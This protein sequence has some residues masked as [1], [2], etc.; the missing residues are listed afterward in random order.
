MLLG[1]N[2]FFSAYRESDLFGQAIFIGLFLLS[3]FSWL[4]I[5]F[6]VV[7][8]R[9][10]R[11]GASYLMRS[12]P[13]KGGN[14]LN[15]QPEEGAFLPQN[16]NLF[17]EVYQTLQEKCIEILNKNHMAQAEKG[18]VHALLSASDIDLIDAQIEMAIADR[19]IHLEKNLFFLGTT[20]ALAPFLGL[21]GTVWGILITLSELKTRTLGGSGEVLH[22]L[23]MALATTV[24][25]L[26]V[27]IP[28]LVGH[29]YLR[30]AMR[31]LA[32][33]MRSWSAQ[34]LASIE[35]LYRRV[36]TLQ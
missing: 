36:E 3:I 28:A 8:L 15:W 33:D 2:P 12:L 11:R 35:M 30:A 29:N 24:L 10:V 7:A 17:L 16:Y 34:Q 27:A 1:S 26:L 5:L 25:G 19:S 20:V 14:P 22:G 32:S 31:E 23:S 21:L 18:E 6:K 4:I 9:R 13:Q